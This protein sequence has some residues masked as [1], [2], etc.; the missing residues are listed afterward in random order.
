LRTA[1]ATFRTGLK[2]A[3]LLASVGVLICAAITALAGMVTLGLGWVTAWLLGAIVGSTDAAAVF[4]LLQ[5]S[6]VTLNERVAATLEIESGV[7]DPMA[8]YLTLA[9]IGVAD[10]GAAGSVGTHAAASNPWSAMA[11]TLPPPVCSAARVSWPCTC[12][13]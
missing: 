2:P 8:V 7:N 6:G 12:S 1:Y 5:R 11:L 9:F 13:G 4:A 10:V 3:S